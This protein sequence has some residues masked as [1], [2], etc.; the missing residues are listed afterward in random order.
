MLFKIVSN[1]SQFV[2]NFATAD[3]F[4]WTDTGARSALPPVLLTDYGRVAIN[5]GAVTA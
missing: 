1:P 4:D 3:A 5:S 2:R